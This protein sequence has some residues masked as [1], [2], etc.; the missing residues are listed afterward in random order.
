MFDGDLVTYHQFQFGD[1]EYGLINPASCNAVQIANG[2]AQLTTD[3]NPTHLDLNTGF[4]GK[5]RGNF[6][7]IITK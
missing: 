6:V 2:S 5:R 1:F 7:I 3:C 4:L